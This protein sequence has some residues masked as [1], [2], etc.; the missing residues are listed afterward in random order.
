MTEW[1]DYL[2]LDILTE[3]SFGK[4]FDTK[5][6]GEN[7]K[8]WVPHDVVRYLKFMYPVRPQKKKKEVLNQRRRLT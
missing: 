2:I 8:K 5:E 1:S 3:L 7:L 6:P 4:S